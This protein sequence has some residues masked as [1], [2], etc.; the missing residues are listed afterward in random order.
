M[1]LKGVAYCMS[2]I[3]EDDGFDVWYRLTH[4]TPSLSLDQFLVYKDMHI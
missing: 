2:E 4:H 1:A 3:P